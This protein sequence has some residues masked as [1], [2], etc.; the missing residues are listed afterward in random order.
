MFW[1]LVMSIDNC[2]YYKLASIIFTIFAIPSFIIFI[3]YM[4]HDFWIERKLL[5]Q[6]KNKGMSLLH[7]KG[8]LPE[9]GM[10]WDQIHK[11]FLC[12]L[13]EQEVKAIKNLLQKGILVDDPLKIFGAGLYSHLYLTKSI[14][15]ITKSP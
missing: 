3:W 12:S 1:Q 5:L 9:P 2:K 7:N 8:F 4:L 11:K 14:R 13:S 6:F 10:R 15:I